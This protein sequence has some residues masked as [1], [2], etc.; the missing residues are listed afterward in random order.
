MHK[1]PR[2]YM[3]NMHNIMQSYLAIT[4]QRII[5]VPFTCTHA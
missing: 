1:K 2:K 5:F 4:F 3:Y